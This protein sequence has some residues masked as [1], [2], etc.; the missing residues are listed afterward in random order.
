[1][2]KKNPNS[3]KARRARRTKCQLDEAALAEVVTKD[4][5]NQK[6]AAEYEASKYGICIKALKREDRRY[7]DPIRESRRLE[8]SKRAEAL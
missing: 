8:R 3:K 7:K 6:L 2:G 5:Q 1:M 4:Y